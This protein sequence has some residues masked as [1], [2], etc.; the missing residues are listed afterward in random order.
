MQ[1]KGSASSE[2][3][4][5]GLQAYDTVWT[6][7]YAIDR[8]ID[9]FKNITF[10]SNDKLNDMKTS[11]LQLGKLK[12]FSNGS[13]LLNKILQ[14]NFTGLSGHIQFNEDRNIESGGYDVINIAH[15][16]INIVG[17]WSNV[18]GFSILPPD[19][20]QGKQTNYSR[21]DQKLQ[22]I[23]W[24]GGKTE[25]PRGWVIADNERP[26]VIGV[27]YRASF[28]DFVTEVNKSHKIEGYCIDVFLE[29][30]KLVPYD[31]PY[32]FEP[33]GDGRFNPNYNE[34]TQ[35]VAEDVSK[36]CCLP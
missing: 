5:Y 7:A 16:S 4:S 25:R 28:V 24:P 6:V 31:V 18:S 29:A 21:V 34:L 14:M 23:T 26:L 13:S 12:I 15:M 27:P 17:Y 9:E 8:F 2:M 22:K 10:S 19:T 3:N 33:F 35:M 20:R 1:E 36:Y 32:R 30:R 11:D